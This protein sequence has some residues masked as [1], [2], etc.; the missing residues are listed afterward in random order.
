M[1]TARPAVSPLTRTATCSE[2]PDDVDPQVIDISAMNIEDENVEGAVDTLP[3]QDHPEL[4]DLISAARKLPEPRSGSFRA[5]LKQAY[6][7]S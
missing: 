1:A 4:E 6:R 5:W 7:N 2:W 3:V